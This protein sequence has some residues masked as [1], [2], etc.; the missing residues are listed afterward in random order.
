MS[1][2][3]EPKKT[4]L[5]QASEDA[6]VV[7]TMGGRMHVRSDETAQAT[8]HGQIVF[9]ADFLAT[10]GVFNRCVQACPLHY[11]SPS[12]SRPR[13]VLGTPMLGRFRDAGGNDRAAFDQRKR[14]HGHGDGDAQ[15]HEQQPAGRRHAG[16]QRH[17]RSHSPG[18]G[19]NSGESGVGHVPDHGRRRCL[20]GWNANGNGYYRC[21]GLR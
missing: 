8:P 17:D 21:D 11:S 4:V 9:F 15:Q 1:Q 10:A 14:R 3:N 18:D 6:M 20:G 16:Q 12:A 13:E 7:D 19:L 2:A 5:A